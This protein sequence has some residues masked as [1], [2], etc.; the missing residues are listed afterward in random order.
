MD[1]VTMVLACSL[2][3]DNTLINAM[4]QV[5]SQNKP[6]VVSS[7][8]QPNTY[9]NASKASNYTMNQLHAGNQVDI[10]LMQIPS[11]WLKQPYANVSELFLPCKNMVT[12]TKVLNEAAMHCSE[13][14]ASN[15]Q[16]CMLSMYKT[17]N[18]TAGLDY[19]NAVLSYAQNHPWDAIYS[20]AEAKNPAGFHMIAGD[21]PT[22]AS[23]PN[24]TSINPTTDKTRNTASNYGD[25]NSTGTATAAADTNP[26]TNYGAS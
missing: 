25:Y 10:G 3:P 11:L 1:L 5:G 16:A 2:Y 14:S 21:A 15:Q 22:N 9:P 26:D 24:A 8:G 12:A 19:A 7:S 6:Y 13:I 23:T 4:V 17:G 20:A 18:P